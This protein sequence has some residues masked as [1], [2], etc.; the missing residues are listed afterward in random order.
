MRIR[1]TN[2]NLPKAEFGNNCPEGFMMDGNGNCIPIQGDENVQYNWWTMPTMPPVVRND[3]FVYPDGT[4]FAP[5]NN[6][7]G[8]QATYYATKDREEENDDNEENQ[9][10]NRFFKNVRN[11]Y[12]K[13]YE[14]LGKAVPFALAITD[15][16]NSEK[17]R[18]DFDRYKRN[19]TSTDNLFPEIPSWMDNRGDYV[20]SGSRYGEFRPDRYVSNKGMY[21]SRFYPTMASGGIIPDAIDM[22]FDIIDIP[23]VYTSSSNVNADAINVESKEKGTSNSDYAALRTWD[24]ISKEYSGVENLGIWRKKTGKNQK[25]SDHYTGGALDIGIKDPKIGDEI[26]KRLMEE[27]KERNIKYIIWN[28][29]IWNPSISNDWRPYKGDSPHTDHVHVSFYSNTNRT[30]NDGNNI[31]TNNPLNIHYG[32]FSM[33]YGAKKG[34]PDNGG[35]IS[36]FPN[37]ES[38]IQSAKDLLFGPSY[39][40]L[41]ITQARNK[42]VNGD[43]S[44]QHESSRYILKEFGNN[45]KKISDLTNEERDKLIK[46]F[47]KW[48]GPKG[49]NKI[50]NM[51]LYKEGGIY[52]IDEDE[53][54]RI[55]ENGGEIEFI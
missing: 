2:R 34:A 5:T 35:N 45:D 16:F 19:F 15:A 36:V 43:P 8:Q 51:K 18:K 47:A 37:L 29:K 46:L 9:T 53:I 32:E 24:D 10:K 23:P 52:N 11:E 40:N 27:A 44:A 55:I 20:V 28:N 22:P 25:P 7:F 31:E 26:S 39:S 50:K 3:R 30:K 41:T 6:F 42:W 12:D 49:Y 1:I 54:K 38:G 14:K 48:E 33:Q 17:R 13:A 21:N 4:S